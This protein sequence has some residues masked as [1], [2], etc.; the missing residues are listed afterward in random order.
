MGTVKRTIDFDNYQLSEKSIE[1]LNALDDRPINYSDIPAHTSE[2]MR[3][4]KRLAVE[5]RKKQMFSLR[6]QTSTINWW[7]SLGDGYTSIMARF[8]DEARRHP[9]WI[10]KCL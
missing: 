3:K 8:L 9:E 1:R 7:K 4:M 10:K 2:E 5:M 6:L